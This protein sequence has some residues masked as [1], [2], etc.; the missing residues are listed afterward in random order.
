MYN[1]EGLHGL[2]VFLAV[3]IGSQERIME[4]GKMRKIVSELQMSPM[5]LILCRS[6]LQ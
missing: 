5:L 6:P 3:L 1:K 2:L 4:P